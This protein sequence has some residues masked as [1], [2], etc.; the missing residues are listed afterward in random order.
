MELKDDSGAGCAL[1]SGDSPRYV[2]A[3]VAGLFYLA[4]LVMWRPPCTRQPPV[5]DSPLY[6]TARLMRQP[7]LCDSSLDLAPAGPDPDDPVLVGEHADVGHRIGVQCDHVGVVALGQL[8]AARGLRAQ[9]E[10]PGRGGRLDRV[11]R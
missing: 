10:R 3:L 7:A 2:T 9:G 1:G 5:C 8:P 11:E 6:A 4:G